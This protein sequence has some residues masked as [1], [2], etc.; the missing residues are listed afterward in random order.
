MYTL[1]HLSLAGKLVNGFRIS[2]AQQRVRGATIPLSA[3]TALV[4]SS[5][6]SHPFFPPG[7]L[8]EELGDGAVIERR[9]RHFY[10]VY[11]RFE[12]GQ[13]RFSGVSHRSCLTLR[14]AVLRYLGHYGALMKIDRVTIDRKL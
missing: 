2:E 8:P 6:E 12:I 14:G 7:I 3:I 10:R 11:E 4:R 5:L 13:M 9:G 1:E